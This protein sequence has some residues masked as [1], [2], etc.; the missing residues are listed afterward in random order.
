MGT[1]F[2][3]INKKGEQVEI[4][5]RGGTPFFRWLNGFGETLKDRRKFPDKTEVFPI[6]NGP[7]GIETLG[8]IR[9]EMRQIERAL[10]KK[11][12]LTKVA[13]GV[14]DKCMKSTA[15]SLDIKIKSQRSIT[16]DFTDLH[17]ECEF[18]VLSDGNFA[19]RS[20]TIREG[21]KGALVVS[22]GF[23]S[24]TRERA[25]LVM[26]TAVGK[27]SEMLFKLNTKKLGNVFLSN[28]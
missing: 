15:K 21:R 20:F 17:V 7:Q 10:K 26:L 28:L 22:H 9:I 6:D 14:I 4:A 12:K 24:P 11:I 3:M 5:K 1:I 13:L 27:V 19:K 2:G 25:D 16:E 8:D 23:H 18:E